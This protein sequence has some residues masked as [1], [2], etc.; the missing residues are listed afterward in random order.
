MSEM[1]YRQ[2]GDYQIPNMQLQTETGE[3]KPLGKYG[4]MR[5]SFLEQNNP[6]L[7]ND[8]IL[9]ETLFPHL[10]KIEETAKARI[11]LLMKQYLEKNPAP[12]KATNQMGWVQH[13]N[14]L[15]AQAEE[16]VMTELINS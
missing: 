1:T 12:D 4:R 9:T 5:R 8:M 13:M 11:E 14:S 2:T 7:L 6:M 3:V 10:W 16:V 15:K